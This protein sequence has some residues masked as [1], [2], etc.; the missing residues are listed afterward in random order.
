MNYN[1]Y[2]IINHI[3]NK[4]FDELKEYS[5]FIRQAKLFKFSTEEIP[6]KI[7]DTDYIAGWYGY[8]DDSSITIAENKSFEHT[9]VLSSEQKQLIKHLRNDLKTKIVF[10]P[11]HTC[12]DYETVIQKGLEHY[13]HLVAEALC[14]SPDNDCLKAMRISLD[15]ACNYALRFAEIAKEKVE[16]TSD[17]HEK[18]RLKNIYSALCQV[19]RFG[20][21]NFL[22]AV[23][24]LWI[25][26]SLIPMAEMSWASIS[27]GRI[28]QYLYPFYKK[29]LAE[30]GTKE[31]V[32]EILKN[33]FVLLDSYGD[34]ACAM[35]IGGMDADGKDMINDLSVIFIEVEKEM[36]RRA[37]IFAVRVTP[38]IPEDVFD[39]LIDFDLFKIGQPTFYG[40]LPCREAVMGRGVPTREAVNF[41]ANSCMGLIVPGQE[42]ADMWGIKFNSHLPLELAVN[43]GKP[44]STELGLNLEINSADIIDFEQLLKQ[45]EN[46]FSKLMTVCAKLYETVAIDSATNVPDPLL[47]ALT[48]G[49]IE[50][51]SDRAVG[52]TYNTVTVETMGLVNTCDSL[53]AINELVF[54]KKKY[55]LNELV[56]AAKMNYEGYEDVRLDISKCQKYGTNNPEVNTLFKRICKIVSTIC[57]NVS[58]DNRL[59]LPSLHTLDV[60]VGYGMMLYATLDGRKKGDPVNKNA[61]PSTQLKKVEH[62][63]QILSAAAFD[64]TDFSG[65]QPIDLYF[66]RAWFKTKESRDKIK[67]LIRT[68]LQLG[69]LQ[70]Q[71]NSVDIDLLEKAHK[72]PHDYPF[73]IIRK[74]GYSVRF[75]ELDEI[76]RAEFIESAKRMEHYA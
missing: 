49:C 67:T 8:E 10:T 33:L 22:E 54:E 5:P 58:H 21:R 34:G 9:D 47:S 48:K 73:V 32:K 17:K 44:I 16:A 75:N 13:M 59:F 15:A 27:T 61:N 70:F 2:N 43:G 38:N 50:N 39:S 74:G 56:T 35:N 24:S 57:K 41:S 60:N 66:D 12:I 3:R 68:Y 72:A 37:P 6:L 30:G 76:T 52:A 62:T 46:Y 36:Q 40:E 25:M 31:E 55:T 51:R 11:A 20:A 7:T 19:P 65:G 63:S 42:F 53:S 28:D 18:V 1:N 71:V 29:H 26:H 4:Y 23:Q 45:Y 69:G 14:E 64:Q